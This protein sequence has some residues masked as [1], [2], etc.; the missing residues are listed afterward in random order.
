M[1]Y[2]VDDNGGIRSRN[3]CVDTFV[4]IGCQHGENVSCYLGIPAVNWDSSSAQR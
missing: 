3:Q 4:M 1:V 2:S